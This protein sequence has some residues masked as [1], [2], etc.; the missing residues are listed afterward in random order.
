MSI[1]R[2]RTSHLTTNRNIKAAVSNQ[3]DATAEKIQLVMQLK[4]IEIAIVADAAFIC[5]PLSYAIIISFST[6]S[7]GSAAAA[8]GPD[9]RCHV[10]SRQFET[11]STF[12][13]S[14]AIS[15]VII[16][17]PTTTRP[18]RQDE[19]YNGQHAGKCESRRLSNIDG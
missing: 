12:Q 17:A 6:L 9:G 13:K 3:I 15:A 5:I 18:P 2:T 1:T 14:D 7:D 10:C 8:A 16:L 4:R 19:T 11:L